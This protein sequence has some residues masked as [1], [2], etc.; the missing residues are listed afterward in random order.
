MDELRLNASSTIDAPCGENE[1][2]PLAILSAGAHGMYLG[3]EWEL[4]SWEVKA[5][6]SQARA[7][8]SVSPIS[9]K[10]MQA[11]GSNLTFPSLY[12]GTYSGDVDDGSNSLKEWFWN[13]KVPQSLRDNE[14]E[15]WTELC[16]GIGHGGR[17][18]LSCGCALPQS[19]YDAVAASGV[20]AI[21]Q[22]FGW[23]NGSLVDWQYREKDWPDGF[24][25]GANARKAGLKSSL[26]MGG[27]YRNVDLTTVAGRDAELAAVEKR[28]DA[29]WFDMWRTDKYSAK[30][31]PMPDT[32]QGVSNFYHIMDSMISSRPG[33]RYENCANGGRY[34][35][36]STARRMT[37]M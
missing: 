35:A 28:Y 10:L 25:F 11:S 16:Y 8:V 12:F 9:E 23:Y 5:S 33:F 20:E 14:N 2:I 7:S 21:K 1:Y 27:T 3:F 36:F 15:P 6:E 22:D 29:G 31:N 26:Y 24:N 34:K 17:F 13:Y 19:F 30:Y 37:F 32:F 18:G 4:G